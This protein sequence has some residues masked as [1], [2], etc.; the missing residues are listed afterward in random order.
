MFCYLNLRLGRYATGRKRAKQSRV[1]VI[2][3]R[4]YVISDVGNGARDVLVLR[5]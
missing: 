4:R 3:W 1:G 5:H 2:L